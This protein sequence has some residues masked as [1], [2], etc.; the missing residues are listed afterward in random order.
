MH[1]EVWDGL[2]GPRRDVE[3][4][5]KVQRCMERAQKWYSKVS[6]GCPTVHS[7]CD[8]RNLTQGKF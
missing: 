4:H 1:E 2:E 6:I 3:G 7:I 5:G 8:N